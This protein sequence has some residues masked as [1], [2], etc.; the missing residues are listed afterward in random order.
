MQGSVQAVLQKTTE[1]IVYLQKA[2]KNLIFPQVECFGVKEASASEILL[3]FPFKFYLSPLYSDGNT[4]KVSLTYQKEGSNTKASIFWASYITLFLILL[5]KLT[6]CTYLLS[7]LSNSSFF[8]GRG[9]HR[10]RVR[11]LDKMAVCK[12]GMNPSWSQW[13]IDCPSWSQF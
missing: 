4:G 12:V 8:K 5:T 9:I 13:W 3:F 7:F 10:K 1:R 2:G 11:S 6:F